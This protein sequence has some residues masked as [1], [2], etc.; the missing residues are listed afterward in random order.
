M[1]TRSWSAEGSRQHEAEHSALR[2]TSWRRAASGHNVFLTEPFLEAGG[3]HDSAV[4][5]ETLCPRPNAQGELEKGGRVRV[6]SLDGSLSYSD[7][8]Q[9]LIGLEQPRATFMVQTCV[10]FSS[11]IMCLFICVYASEEV[12]IQLYISYIVSSRTL[13]VLVIQHT[14][15]CLNQVKSPGRKKK[16][17]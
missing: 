2:V 12:H 10:V 5:W 11:L 4:W 7:T 17:K 1:R 9:T 3:R 15:F 14:H 13:G 8:W 16:H 6:L